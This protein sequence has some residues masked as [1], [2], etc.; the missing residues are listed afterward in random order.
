[1]TA[2]VEPRTANPG[3]RFGPYEIV[4]AIGTGGMGRVY[5][6][7]DPRLGRFVAIKILSPDKH[8]DPDRL[9]RFEQEARAA[10]AL[11]HPNIL[12]IYETGEVAGAFYIAMEYVEGTTLRQVLGGGA[13]TSRQLLDTAVQIAEGLAKAHAAGI[14]HRDLKPENVMVTP[15]GYVKILD[16]GLAKLIDPLD[17]ESRSLT[18][19]ISDSNTATR[20][21]TLLGTVSYM[22]P[23]QARGERTDFRSDIFSFGSLLYEMASG[24][25][26]F[27]GRSPVDTLSQILN[28]NPP[29]LP[30]V[31]PDAA[32][33]LV[34]IIEKCLA[35]EPAQRYQST[36]DLALDLKKAREELVLSSSGAR[37]APRIPA[38]RRGRSDRAARRAAA[39]LG[40]VVAL[41]A[42]FWLGRR[43][44]ALPPDDLSSDLV[45]LTRDG[46]MNRRPAIAPD[47][48]SFVFESS[49]DG[50]P[51][52]YLQYFAGGSP[53][54]VTRDSSV[55]AE[56]YPAWSPDGSQIAYERQSADGVSILLTAP[57]GGREI[58]VVSNGKWPA[59][60]PDASRL[61]FC[62]P[63]QGEVPPRL[64]ARTMPS[65]GESEVAPLL[66]SD[67]PP[68]P[69]PD[70]RV[71]AFVRSGLQESQH[72]GVYL[73]ETPHGA[74]RRVLSANFVT[75]RARIAWFP[76]S[77][78][79]VVSRD[80]GSEEGANLWIADT[81][82]HILKRLTNANAFFLNPAV[83]SDGEFLLCDP[84]EEYGNLWKIPLTG[85]PEENSLRAER[86]TS[87][88]ATENEVNLSPDERSALFTTNRE[89]RP[90]LWL[91]DLAT[92]ETRP[93]E[94]GPVDS[95][96]GAFS[97]SGGRIAFFSRRSGRAALWVISSDGT[98][99]R[100]VDQTLRYAD[101]DY[102]TSPSAPHWRSESEILVEAAAQGSED[103][104]YRISPAGGPPV[105]WQRSASHLIA[106]DTDTMAAI[107]RSTQGSAT[108]KLYQA[109]G[110]ADLYPASRLFPEDRDYWWA[111]S[112]GGRSFYCLNALPEDGVT[113][114]FNLFERGGSTRPD[115]RLTRFR[116]SGLAYHFAVSRDG[117]FA[118]GARNEIIADITR[119]K[120]PM[121]RE[122]R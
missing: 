111:F 108:V 95:Y 86:M 66:L 91:L 37:L 42:V 7:R 13:L 61:Y 35:K 11:N 33:S 1:M 30:E 102:S 106:S 40:L 107:V 20:P 94:F 15:D 104:I 116:Q 81:G 48:K 100:L 41:G 31:A 36:R 16:F 74:P 24:R 120:N 60:S 119:L 58:S 23:E 96:L 12:T 98:G 114:V 25:R 78:R 19:T 43:S 49:R 45:R 118:I 121:R 63:G 109:G 89:G 71:I 105:L 8:G 82:G 65:G 84:Y 76:D 18:E 64:M 46:A 83:S 26:A 4:V 53:T 56:S 21:G 112:P 39:A 113:R 3:D 47:G 75:P 34:W 10:S 9:R 67:G 27:R 110:S 44:G 70:G 97:P 32:A 38:D 28:D 68:A 52:L 122:V 93:L 69:S 87:G 88:R 101:P 2:S 50:S 55:A 79:F 115:R 90:K 22:S 54:R 103:G 51:R 85:T 99:P 57:V 73:M 59:W 72:P 14:V 117:K 80:N 92:R 6:A 17:E 29:P 5:K 77:R 62:R